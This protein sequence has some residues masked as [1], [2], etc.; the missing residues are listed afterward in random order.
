MGSKVLLQRS[1]G[2]TK[3][4]CGHKRPT[5]INAARLYGC[6]CI[7]PTWHKGFGKV[8]HDSQNEWIEGVPLQNLFSKAS[9][10]SMLNFKNSSVIAA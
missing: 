8:V 6:I 10:T 9:T 2:P 1:E 4:V 5:E 3:A 7:H